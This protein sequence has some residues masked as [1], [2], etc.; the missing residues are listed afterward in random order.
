MRRAPLLLMLLLLA[1]HANPSPAPGAGT[2]STLLDIE[3][4]L[5][6]L[7][8]M[9]AGL[10]AG[11]RF[12][13]L[14]LSSEDMHVTGFAGCNQM[15]GRYTMDGNNL[16][17]IQI[18]STKMACADGMDLEQQYLAALDATREFRLEGNRL[19]LIGVSGVLAE[20]ETRS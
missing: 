19:Q 3:W 14:Q 13:T 9:P 18:Y 6:T 1:C 15:G 16:R 7:N 10:G 4:H 5:V 12:A 8:R 20:F 11:G 17:F 2:A